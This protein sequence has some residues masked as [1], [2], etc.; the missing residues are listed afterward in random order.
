MTRH[1][2]I[3]ALIAAGIVP[4]VLRA[5]TKNLDINDARILVPVALS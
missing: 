2:L 4:T 1:Q 5:G 3:L